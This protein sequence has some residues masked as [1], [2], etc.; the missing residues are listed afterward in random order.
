MKST[1]NIFSKPRQNT[2]LL[3][4]TTLNLLVIVRFPSFVGSV[5]RIR[6]TV[7][8]SIINLLKAPDEYQCHNMRRIVY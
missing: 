3:S 7:F 2:D 1:A 6:T 5:F 4:K 8:L